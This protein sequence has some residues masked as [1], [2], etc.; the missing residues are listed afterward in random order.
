MWTLYVM[1][2]VNWVF[3]L[4]VLWRILWIPQLPSIIWNINLH[5]H[6]QLVYAFYEYFVVVLFL[7]TNLE[8]S[9]GMID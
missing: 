8:N 1:V 2:C 6:I 5:M 4:G 3:N 7:S 9:E